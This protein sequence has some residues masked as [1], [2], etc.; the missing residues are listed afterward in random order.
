MNITIRPE[1]EK[2]FRMVEILTREA[3]RDLYKPGCDEHFILHKMRKV[4]AFVR[5]LDFVAY[6]DNEVV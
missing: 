5:E 2:D 3:F 4:P 1:E 6:D